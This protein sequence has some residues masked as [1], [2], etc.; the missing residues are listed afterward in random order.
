M[1]HSLTITILTMRW[2][3][4]CVKW[5]IFVWWF[6]IY[7][8][9]YIYSYTTTNT[10]WGLGNWKLTSEHTAATVGLLWSNRGHRSQDYERN[11]L[12]ESKIPCVLVVACIGVTWSRPLGCKGV[13]MAVSPSQHFKSRPSKEYS[14][15]KPLTTFDNW[16]VY[17]G[18]FPTEH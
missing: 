3:V 10:V 4:M 14:L 13:N 8:T 5:E 18:L 12:E 2:T 1:N 17:W 9:I 6:L 11:E 7:S 15:F 16:W